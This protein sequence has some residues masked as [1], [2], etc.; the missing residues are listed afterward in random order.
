MPTAHRE[1]VKPQTDSIAMSAGWRWS[2]PLTT[3]VGNGYVYSSKYIADEEAEAEL[4]AA[5]GMV[6]DG[7]ARVLQMRVGRVEDS[8]A[9]NCLAVGLSQ[10]FIEPLEATA[11]H[12]VI[13]TAL[14]F[15]E[16]YE[17]GGFGPQNR[18]SFNRRIA[19]KYEGIR[20]YIVAHYRLNQRNDTQYWR[21]NAANHSLSD[22]LK[23]MMT[24]WFTHEDI[25]QLNLQQHAGNPHYANMSWHCL[26]A[27]YGTFPPQAKMQP[28][29]QGLAAGD[30]Q[31]ARAMLAA[32]ATNFPDYRP[33]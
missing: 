31:A 4:R 23:A 32:C 30:L 20:D 6:E 28:P 15:A 1:A 2:I 22:N 25:G 13:V 16:A 17:S 9:R 26:F 33:V 11:L 27:G 10:G 21:D 19:A 29:P 18:D 5:I 8:W 14:D 3:R 7:E 24:A 12:I